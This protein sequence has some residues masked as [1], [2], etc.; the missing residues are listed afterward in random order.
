MNL[1]VT[2]SKL[3]VWGKGSLHHWTQAPRR[4]EAE[5]SLSLASLGVSQRPFAEVTG[6]GHEWT[7]KD[8]GHHRA[9]DLAGPSCGPGWISSRDA[10]RGQLLTSP[11]LRSR[12]EQNTCAVKLNLPPG[13][14]NRNLLHQ[15]SPD[16]QLS[17]GQT[18]WASFCPQ[19][20]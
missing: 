12:S 20:V 15:P 5:Q 14:E 3:A 1:R 2:S 10:V 9:G 18:P 17:L 8:Q 6:W 19:M 13:V 11:A 16:E 4:G 7:L